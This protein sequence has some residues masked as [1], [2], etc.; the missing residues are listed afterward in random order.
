MI[1]TLLQITLHQIWLNRN[2]RK[3]EPLTFDV[4]QTNLNSEFFIKSCFTTALRTKYFYST[5]H[6]LLAQFRQRFCH[7]PQVCDVMNDTLVVHIL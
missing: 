3:F 5:T 4:T 6:N 2:S 1:V 7:T